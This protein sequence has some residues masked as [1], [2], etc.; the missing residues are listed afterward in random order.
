MGE[1]ITLGTY[2][3]NPIEWIVIDREESEKKLLLFSKYC[4]D[5]CEYSKSGISNYNRYSNYENSFIRTWLKKFYDS[6]FND[7]E[8]QR[9][10]NTNVKTIFYDNIEFIAR[11]GHL[12]NTQEERI[13][14]DEL[15]LLSSEE[16]KKYKQLYDFNLKS[17]DSKTIGWYLRDGYEGRENDWSLS[18]LLIRYED[19]NGEYLYTDCG[20]IGGVR[21]AMW[22]KY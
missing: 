16:Y 6:C 1:I 19:V 22:V 14:K 17:I 8:K 4:V 3:E 12:F 11:G 2:N 15:F 13:T 21:P 5:Y 20:T 7:I 10:L 18:N 9:I